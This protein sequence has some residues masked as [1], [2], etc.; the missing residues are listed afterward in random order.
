MWV[1]SFS[2]ILQSLPRG[3]KAGKKKSPIFQN[4]EEILVW[5]LRLGAGARQW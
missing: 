1:F 2:R 4:P 3:E 5:S